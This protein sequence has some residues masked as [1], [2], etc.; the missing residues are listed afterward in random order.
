MLFQKE[1]H[2]AF[3]VM[4][5]SK[6]MVAA[7]LGEIQE[8]IQRGFGVLMQII[9]ILWLL[10]NLPR[11]LQLINTGIKIPAFLIG[12]D[13]DTLASITG[14][15]LGMLCGTAWIPAVWRDVQ[16][17]ECLL[18]I[19]ELLLVPNR[20]E[21]SKKIVSEVKKNADVWENTP[22]GWIRKLSAAEYEAGKDRLISISKYQS[23]LGQT[24]YIKEY[25]LV[26]W[27]AEEQMLIYA[28]HGV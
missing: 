25:R 14:G 11:T 28:Q 8:S 4:L 26:D 1:V 15:L 23:E 19:T 21:V 18:Q 6:S 22:I 5:R 2:L 9:V 24:F 7:F 20:K 3:L 16:D 12:T 10:L 13:T 27:N 17:Y